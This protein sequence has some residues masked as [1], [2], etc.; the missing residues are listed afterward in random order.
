MKAV[1]FVENQ[2][3]ALLGTEGGSIIYWDFFNNK[4]KFICT[5]FIFLSLVISKMNGHLSSVTVLKAKN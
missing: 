5:I 1:E 3:S 2:T 4:S